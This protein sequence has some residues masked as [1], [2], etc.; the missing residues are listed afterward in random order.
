MTFTVETGSG[1]PGANAYTSIAF[2]DSYL[3]DRGRET[4]NLWST[5]T[6]AVK[7]THIIA[8]TDYIDRR[9]GGLF[10]GL[11]LRSL[12]DGREASGT[13]TVPS[14]PL[15]TEVVTIGQ[16]TYRFV[17]TLAQEND[18]LIGAT[19]ADTLAA[20]VAAVNSGGNGT[21]SH[22]DTIDHYE[23]DAAVA[24]GVVTFTAL[25]EGTNGN[26]I[27]LSTDVTGASV[28]AATLT[29]GLDEGPQPLEFPRTSFVGIPLELRQATAEYAVR[30]L[31]AV[32]A[33]DPTV[34]GTGAKVQRK[35]E[36]VGPI[37]EETEYVAGAALRT[38]SPYP[39]ADA[40]L[41]RLTGYREGRVYR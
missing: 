14:N 8:A 6:D 11:R 1:T 7:R 26:E 33:P 27:A 5:Q 28:S 12:I 31:G 41:R 36:K 9:F 4:E 16:T 29:G 3:T 19:A 17:A 40:L 10:L 23:V 2:V 39:A 18:I 13:F 32:L 38:W 30:S 20:L 25:T 21:T 24:S 37:E 34:D 15:D 22:A 35:R